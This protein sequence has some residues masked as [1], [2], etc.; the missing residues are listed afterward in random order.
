MY[1]CVYIYILGNP[2]AQYGLFSIKRC[3]QMVQ[4]WSKVL[5]YTSSPF[6]PSWQKPR[7]KKLS[8]KHPVGSRHLKS[9]V[10]KALVQPGQ[11]CRIEALSL[12]GFLKLIPGV[13]LPL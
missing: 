13:L 6:L 12:V 1:V 9:S 7:R 8:P 3:L 2:K 4:V 5:S 10:L 11:N